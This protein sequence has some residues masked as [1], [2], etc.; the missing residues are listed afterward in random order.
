MNKETKNDF[1]SIMSQLDTFF[2]TYLVKKAP[3]L[4]DNIKEVIVKYYP[5]VIIISLIFTLPLIL[6][7]LGLSALVAPFAFLG[8][9]RNGVTFSLANISI[10]VTTVLNTLAI[11][12]LLKRQFAGWQYLYYSALVSAT[13]SLLMFNLG[14]F[15]I[16]MAISMYF[17]YQIKSYYK[18]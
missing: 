13:F 18:K 12:G 16:G 14:S 17:L 15:V 10:L 2:D 11:S 4:P 3:T 8:G 7:L 5:Y 6:G 1:N 9:M